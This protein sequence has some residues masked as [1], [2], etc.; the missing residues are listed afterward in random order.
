MHTPRIAPRVGEMRLIPLLP[1]CL[2]HVGSAAT[3]E[4][5]SNATPMCLYACPLAL[6]RPLSRTTLIAWLSHVWVFL[7]TRCACGSASPP[8]L[9]RKRIAQSLRRVTLYFVKREKEPKKLTGFRIDAELLT[10]AQRVRDDEGIPV[11]VQ[12]EKA[13]R[14]W[15]EKRGSLPKPRKAR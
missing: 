13:L 6:S 11:T 12:I 15:L 7:A 9:P 4:Q 3:H 5:R 2:E 1:A 8:R 10:A 14:E